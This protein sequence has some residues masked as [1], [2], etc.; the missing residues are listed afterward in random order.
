MEGWARTGDGGTVV[1][2][3]HEHHLD[4]LA[5]VLGQP[6]PEPQQ[7]D[8]AADADLV[9]EDLGD[10]HAGVHELLA[11]LVGDGGDERSGLSDKTQLPRP[12]EVHGDLRTRPTQDV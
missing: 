10:G 8:D 2:G 5:G 3:H 9:L 7:R 6:L 11:S 12:R 4:E 1:G